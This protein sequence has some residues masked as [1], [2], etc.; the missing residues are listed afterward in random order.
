VNG[1]LSLSSV[2]SQRVAIDAEA[3]AALAREPLD[4][5][6][7]SLGLGCPDGVAPA[8]LHG[9][10]LF[11]PG[12]LLPAMVLRSAAVEHNVELMASWCER[13]GALLA[14]HAKTTMA[15]QLMEWQAARGCWA[16]TCATPAHLR[17]YLRCGVD[18]V[19]YAN[20]IAQDAL[21][22]LELRGQL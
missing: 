6:W 18:R 1:V 10:D 21:L 15:P 19:F 17:V 2:P 11:S 14:P 8:V 5:Q 4:W 3:V 16:F 7:G 12:V 13:H 20:Q 22:G 9:A